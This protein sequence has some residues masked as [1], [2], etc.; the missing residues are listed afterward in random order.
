MSAS[1]TMNKEKRTKSSDDANIS[2]VK[3]VTSKVT[4]FLPSTITKWFSS[5]NSPN[6]NGS[7]PVTESTDSSTEDEA[8]ESPITTQP[9][10]KRM[11]YNSP[12]TSNTYIPAETKST[13]TN[14]DSI[15]TYS[16]MQ[17]PI[18]R[19]VFRPETNFVSTQLN[20]PSQESI[21]ET[22]KEPYFYNL[23]SSSLNENNSVLKKRKSLF[24]INHEDNYVS[25]S[26][27][28]SLSEPQFKASYLSAPFY[29]RQAIYGRAI[30]AYMNEPNIKQRKSTFVTNDSNNDNVTISHSARRVL[31]LLENYSSPLTEAKRISQFMKSSSNSTLDS[32][33]ASSSKGLSYKTQELHVPSLATILRIKQRSRLMDTTSAARQLIASHSSSTDFISYPAPTSPSNTLKETSDKLTT[34]IKS[35]L[36]RINREDKAVYENN[37][38][39][40]LPTAVLQIDKDNLPKFSLGISAPKQVPSSSIVTATDLPNSLSVVV[41]TETS[42]SD[43]KTNETNVDKGEKELKALKNNSYQFSIPVTVSTETVNTFSMPSKFTFGS[44]E[45]SIEKTLDTKTDNTLSKVHRPIIKVK[46]DLLPKSDDWKCDDCWVSNKPDSATCVCCGGKKPTKNAAKINKCSVCQVVLDK[47]CTNK[48][49]NCEKTSNNNENLK[50]ICTD[51]SQWKC[52]DCWVKNDEGVKN[53]VC[54]GSK[55]PNSLD[56]VANSKHESVESDWKCEVCLIKNKSSVETCAACSEVKPIS[57]NIST[58]I[59]TCQPETTG[60]VSLLK[61][62]IKS[63][64]EKW[65]CVN[66]LVRNDTNVSKCVCCETEKPGTIKE[67]EKKSFNFGL[68]PNMSF[69][70][71]IDPKLAEKK[72]VESTPLTLAAAAATESENNNNILSTTFTFGLP[73]KKPEDKI[74]N[75]KDTPDEIPKSTYTFG[76]PKQ[77]Q[78]AVESTA[79][80]V[81]NNPVL[82]GKFRVDT[83]KSQTVVNEEQEVAK[84]EESKTPVSQP[85]QPIGIFAASAPSD[86]QTKTAD[87]PVSS[88]NSVNNLE[89]NEP[90]NPPLIPTLKS[91]EETV[92]P[93]STFT[94]S[95]SGVK[96]ASNLFSPKVTTSTTTLKETPVSSSSISFFQKSDPVSTSS[97]SFFQKSEPAPTSLSMFN[98]T[99]TTITTTALQPEVSNPLIFSF[100][101]NNVPNVLSQPEQP[102]FTFTFG[103]TNKPE[104]PSIFKAPFG[105]AVDSSIGTNNFT[106]TNANSMSTGN[107]LSGN[108][109]GGLP[110]ANNMTGNVLSGGNNGMSAANPSGLIGNNTMGTGNPLSGLIPPNTLSEA[111][112]LSQTNISSTMQSGG[113]FGAAIK[114]DDMWSSSNNTSNNMFVS[115]AT[116]NNAQK[117]TFNFGSSSPFNSNNV[118]PAP[119]FGSPSQLSQNLFGISNQNSQPSMFSNQIQNSG[120]PNMFGASQPASNSVPTV[121]MFGT[122]NAGVTTNFGSPNP[123]PTFEASSMNPTPAFNFGAQQTTGIFGFGQQQQQQPQQQPHPGGVYNFGATPAGAGSTQ[124]Q[125]NMGSSPYISGRRVRKAIRRTTQR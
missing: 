88:I 78:S 73:K 100:G 16:E 111:N 6:T 113:L 119:T 47:D 3:N 9:P 75:L 61:N 19:N 99:E 39:I 85:L 77:T 14:T 10:A 58:K 22:K 31:D 97:L 76:I 51:L 28:M 34:K 69:K 116:N 66:C 94:F 7:A 40:N 109:L 44:P 121:G 62:I 101:S 117:P 70:F 20:S 92:V 43:K 18:S 13:S 110:G 56:T 68:N 50:P 33:K 86:T 17:S 41:P 11:R 45:R 48:C 30:N 83:P 80:N 21:I 108:T 60:N 118:N 53:C 54:C 55:K 37:E 35:R 32:S 95:S 49:V 23:E 98:K 104:S 12:G 38:P 24:N 29:T 107:A 1:F 96:V 90:L 72:I 124:V 120:P 8:P 36:T 65:E 67:S 57:K 15:A 42:N 71:G 122:P 46:T 114:K 79:K 87:I 106:L 125:F 91:S 82:E 64:T 81:F 5:P 115:N 112:N 52:Q 105:A 25:N 26:T 59:G 89:K 74:D 4:G 93:K 63:Q 2:F 27:N 123:I 84:T 102:K 103:S